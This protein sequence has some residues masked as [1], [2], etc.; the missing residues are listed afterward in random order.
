[1]SSMIY[2]IILEHLHIHLRSET[3]QSTTMLSNYKEEEGGYFRFGRAALSGMLRTQYKVIRKCKEE[4]IATISKEITILQAI[5]TK[6]K[7]S[8]PTYLKYRDR[9]WLHVHTK[10]KIHQFF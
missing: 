7:S 5:A 4:N 10:P 2:H 8:M 6:D 9:G 3:S 1:M